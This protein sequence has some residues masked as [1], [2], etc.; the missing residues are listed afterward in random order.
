VSTAAA[1][2][3]DAG[4]RPGQEE[5]QRGQG[6]TGGQD[7]PGCRA[8]HAER[9][10]PTEPQGCGNQRDGGP[11]T[12]RGQDDDRGQGRRQQ[13]RQIGETARGRGRD[14]YGQEPPP[15]VGDGIGQPRPESGRANR[16][17]RGEQH[18]RDGACHQT[19][20]EAT[21]HGQRGAPVP[22]RTA[23]PSP[24]TGGCQGGGGHRQG[25]QPQPGRAEHADQWRQRSGTEQQCGG[26]GDRGC[27]ARPAAPAPIGTAAIVAGIGTA[28]ARRP[29]RRPRPW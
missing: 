28:G 26:H 5:G 10:Q 14:R 25:Y 12:Q 8:V 7:D 11:L 4:T 22:G 18:R 6:V 24:R 19:S 20:G 27:L 1:A 16:V 17:R 2:A 21:E 23:Q 13:H 9:E 15:S 3:R 29:R